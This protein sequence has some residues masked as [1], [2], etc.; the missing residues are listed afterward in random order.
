MVQA[1]PLDAGKAD[2]L[3]RA[4]LSET[5]NATI[6]AAIKEWQDRIRC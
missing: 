3:G 1:K 2:S 5:T 4:M 6:E